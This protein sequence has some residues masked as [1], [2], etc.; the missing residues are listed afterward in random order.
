MIFSEPL[1]KQVAEYQVLV[2]CA[3]AFLPIENV[4]K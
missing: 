4:G 3:Y 2:L 1:S